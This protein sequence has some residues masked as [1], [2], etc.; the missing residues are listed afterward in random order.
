MAFPAYTQLGRSLSSRD[1][2]V[3]LREHLAAERANNA[4]AVRQAFYTL[5]FVAHQGAVM[6]DAIVLVAIRMLVTRRRLLEWVTA[7]RAAVP[8]YAAGVWRRMWPAP[9]IAI[10]FVALIAAVRPVNLALAAPILI[11]WLLS[12]LAAYRTGRPLG[13]GRDSLTRD[14]R[15]LLRRTARKTWRFFEELVGP[16]D[17]WLI[18]DNYQ[19]NRADVVA[20]RTSPTNIGLQLLVGALR[21]RL[22][23]PERDRGRRL[24]RA[25]VRHPAAD[26]AVSRA[27]PQLVRHQD[28]G[29][30]VPAYIST[31]DSG[32]LAG[33][34]LTLAVGAD[35]ADGAS[36][37][38][39]RGGAGRD[40]QT[41]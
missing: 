21:P 8:L 35:R 9:A 15:A 30:A 24:P 11:L 6:A 19:D 27:L 28:A 2:G 18:P 39:R 34:L 22:R 32:N 1:A 14:E 38:H 31:V 4:N 13:H 17:N 12:P 29:A 40:R 26:A 36:A 20:H 3:P 33:Y 5:V 10:A 25:H 37:D 16:A 23:L 41:P 7:S